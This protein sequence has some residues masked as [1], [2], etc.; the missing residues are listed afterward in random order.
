[1]CLTVTVASPESTVKGSGNNFFDGRD[2]LCKIA[3]A[4]CVLN[5][6]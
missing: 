5:F 2:A 1:M 6:A 4:V 3:V